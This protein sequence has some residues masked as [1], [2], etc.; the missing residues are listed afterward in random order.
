MFRLWRRHGGLSFFLCNEAGLCEVAHHLI[1]R[2]NDARGGS[3]G[4][5]ITEEASALDTD[6]KES[7]CLYRLLISDHHGIRMLS[8]TPQHTTPLAR[9]VQNPRM[10]SWP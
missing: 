8:G 4:T 2:D 1:V 5:L 7:R 9:S 3:A 6:G 10:R